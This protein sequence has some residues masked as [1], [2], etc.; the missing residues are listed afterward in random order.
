[1][2]LRDQLDNDRKK[3]KQKKAGI[4]HSKAYHR[5]FEGYSEIK[6]PKPDG[7]GYSI[8]RIYTGNY[9]RPDLSVNKRVL[10]RVLYIML[11]L[12]MGYLFVSSAVLPLASNSTWYVVITQVV[13]IP[14]LFWI[15]LSFFWYVPARQDLTLDEYRSSSLALKRAALGS[16]AGLGLAVVASLVFLFLNSSASPAA[17]LFCA[18]RY[19]VGGLLALA[20]YF[21]EKKVNYLIIPSGNT[22]PVDEN[23]KK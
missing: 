6:V 3:E 20:M 17:E 13:S 18:A 22:L 2:G 21:V 14:F 10:L 19:L 4:S 11:F 23:E 12:C 7:K 16:A 5:F 1:M 15:L 8:Q 9:Y